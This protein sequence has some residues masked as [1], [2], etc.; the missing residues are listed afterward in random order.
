MGTVSTLPTSSQIQNTSGKS[1]MKLGLAL[2]VTLVLVASHVEMSH[3]SPRT[4]PVEPS[5]REAA[6]AEEIIMRG[7]SERKP[8]E[9]EASSVDRKGHSHNGRWG[10]RSALDRK[11]HSHNG[12]WGGR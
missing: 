1:K 4:A 8:R 5:L 10:G 12:H 6:P 7:A 2:I 11:G 3:G 9:E